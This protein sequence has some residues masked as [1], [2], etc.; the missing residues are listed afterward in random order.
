VSA[1]PTKISGT[2]KY[3][4]IRQELLGLLVRIVEDPE[5]GAPR[6]GEI[7]DELEEIST[8]D[9]E[10]LMVLCES[11]ADCVDENLDDLEDELKII[12]KRTIIDPKEDI[13]RII[14]LLSVLAKEYQILSENHEASDISLLESSEKINSRFKVLS[15]GLLTI[16]EED[17]ARLIDLYEEL[18]EEQKII[19][20]NLTLNRDRLRYVQ[21][22]TSQKIKDI[23]SALVKVPKINFGEL[24]EAYEDMNDEREGIWNR[25]DDN[26]EKII[27]GMNQRAV[28]EKKYLNKTVK[29]LDYKL[30]RLTEERKFAEK[31]NRRQL[32]RNIVTNQDLADNLKDR[33][34]DLQRN[35]RMNHTQ[36]SIINGPANR[37]LKPIEPPNR[38]MKILRSQAADYRF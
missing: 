1:V 17:L 30:K 12:I 2:K 34:R 26:E 32:N 27:N 38:Q 29:L 15:E 23:M 20:E 31:M 33:R 11:V 16:Q 19:L 4:K 24:L 25:Y 35:L 36:R 37:H 8:A 10:H 6:L 14:K 9:E 7:L 22:Q 21:Q 3:E 5:N 28:E 13:E 18:E